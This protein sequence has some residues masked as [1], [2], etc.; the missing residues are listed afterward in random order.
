[1]E[2]NKASLV[3][4]LK[5]SE[6]SEQMKESKQAETM[7]ENFN[8]FGLLTIAYAC[9]YTFCMY[10]N[11]SGITFLLFV[12][13]SLIYICYC[14]A[15]LE[16]S[17]KKNSVFYMISM[18]LLAVSTFC[19]DD[20]RII[21][22]NKVGIFL[23]A[24]SML[25]VIF[26]QTEKWNLGKF[27]NAIWESCKKT[28][29]ALPAPV[30]DARW[31]FKNKMD[32]KNRKYLYALAG[33]VITI[34][35][36]VVVMLLL[37]S[38]DAV[39]MDMTKSM[40][41]GFSI[42]SIVQAGGMVC[43]MFLASYCML[44]QFCKKPV[45][46]E[47]KDS[48]KGEPLLAIPVAAI[49]SLVYLVFSWVQIKG[50]FMGKMKLPGFY[51]YAEYA[52]EGFFQL[53][54]VG[55]LNLVLVLVCLCY[56]RPSK[57]L[58]TVIT[59]M[60]LC[61]FIMLASSAM[62]ML[63]YIQYYYLTFLRILVLWSLA[64]LFLIFVGVIIYIQKESF[65]LF[66]YSMVVVTCLYLGLSFGHPDYWIAKVNIENM[67][68]DRS[69]FF[70]GEAYEDYGFLSY[71]C[72]DATPVM[73]ECMEKEGYDFNYFYSDKEGMYY[74]CRE[75]DCFGYYWMERMR[76]RTEDMSWREF[77][78]SRFLLRKKMLAFSMK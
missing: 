58:R 13:G 64:V 63:I 17:L 67:R 65:P 1:M 70:K 41:R 22:F 54:A 42:D 18:I 4:V 46:E 26:Y 52:R 11:P 43:V 30:S 39:F 68:E 7:K 36:F 2:I 56:F 49:L 6:V 9:F 8:V 35:L 77:N 51:T 37:T 45:R 32:V 38:A 15:K 60:S 50:L 44:A 55:I 53:L 3:E 24:I 23:L 28:L 21:F 61:T 34:P 74:E 5:Q 31:Y 33:L 48:R 12:A 40:L 10:Q 25:L 69:D 78:V 47:V 14:L 19:T 75:K 29:E 76:E 62:R 57:V 20:D 72:A 16:V 66:R 71:L 59:V 73:A 27:I